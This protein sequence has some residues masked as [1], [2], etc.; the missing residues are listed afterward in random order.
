MFNLKG[1]TAL[2]TGVGNKLGMGM[3]HAF[4]LVEHGA[5]V[6]VTGKNE[7]FLNE[8]VEEILK[9]GGS[10]L[11]LYFDVNDQKNIDDV[12]SKTVNHFGSIDI[13]VNNAGYVSLKPSLDI[14]RE[15]WEQ[16]LDV[17]LKA[18]FFCAQAAAKYMTKK[19]WGRII[20]IGSVSSGQVGVGLV[21][22]AHYSA[23]KGGVV[24]MTEALAAEWASLNITVNVIC[25]GSI[26]T[27]MTIDNSQLE[28]WRKER[29]ERIPLKRFGQPKEV[30]S[31]VIFLSSEEASYITGTTIVIDGGF[32]SA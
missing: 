3:S 12:F 26:S 20:N 4:S 17:N 31:A 19:K 1:K 18:Q 11:G 6:V 5:N 15:E 10:A 2:V 22:G 9:K 29:L 32:L 27:P 16:M 24:G 30:S 7:K 13:L 23:A 8:A 14:T 25:P 28:S 21:G